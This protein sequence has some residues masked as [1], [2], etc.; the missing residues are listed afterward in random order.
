MR[1][2]NKTGIHLSMAV[3]LASDDYDY[4]NRPNSIST[5][6]LI[7][8]IRQIILKHRAA[9]I[10]TSKT[11]DVKKQIQDV[12]AFIP[13]TFGTAIHD[14]IE[15]S[16]LR[17]H[18]KALV[19]LG[20]SVDTI[21]RFLINPAP[22]DVKEDSIVIYMEQRS[23]K[24]INGFFVTGK[25]DFVGDGELVDHKTTGAYTYVK[26]SK[27][28]DFMLQGSIY[29]WLNQD[30]ITHDRMI[31]N[32]TFTDWSKKDYLIQGKKGYPPSRIM[33]Y[34]IDLMS[35]EETEKWVYD[36]LQEIHDHKLTPEPDLPLCT[37]EQLWQR[38]TVYKYYKSGKVGTKSTKNFTNFA[39]AQMRLIKDGPGG[40]IV[41]I[42]GEVK[43]CPYCDGFSICSQA[44]QLLDAGLIQ[45]EE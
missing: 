18:R 19:R 41:P 26:K 21:D 2:T 4:D 16:W 43:K 9:A 17:S 23:E 20:Y 3:F 5:T 6:S 44:K 12:S 42:Y 22:A 24:F 28:H 13:S 37:K 29:R 30:I 14:G 25:F 38:D 8:P 27:D 15:G 31:I 1:L 35:I 45:L 11:S 40:L 39:E 33:S 36:A 32:Y 10:E 34:P 7:N